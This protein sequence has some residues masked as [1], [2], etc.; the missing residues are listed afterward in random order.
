MKLTNAK[1]NSSKTKN[2]PNK[3]EIRKTQAARQTKLKYAKTTEKTA[4]KNHNTPNEKPKAPNK[5]SLLTLR[6]KKVLRRQTARATTS[7]KPR[8]SHFFSKPQQPLTPTPRRPPIGG[9]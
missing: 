8:T 7:E 5:I 1:T 9:R 3:A 2:T 4:N 6:Q